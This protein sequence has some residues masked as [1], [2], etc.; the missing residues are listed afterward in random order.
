MQ[1]KD[2]VIPTSLKPE[3]LLAIIIVAEVYKLYGHT[4]TITSIADG[5]HSRQ[6][7]HYVGYAFDCR[8]K[9]LGGDE[10]YDIAEEIRQRLTTDYDVVVEDT[11]L[12]IEY[13]PKR[14]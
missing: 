13:Q 4:L 10:V 6:S 2:S 11:H 3:T 12:H 5:K 1:L 7:L 9:M 14:P 8:T